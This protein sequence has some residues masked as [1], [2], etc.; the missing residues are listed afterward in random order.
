MLECDWLKLI[1]AKQNQSKQ[2]LNQQID[3]LIDNSL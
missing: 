2:K 1:P 3:I